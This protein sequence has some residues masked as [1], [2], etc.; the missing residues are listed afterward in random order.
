MSPWV[1]RHVLAHLPRRRSRSPHR[2]GQRFF[3]LHRGTAQGDPLSSLLFNALLQRV[4]AQLTPDWQRRHQTVQLGHTDASTLT[5]L[6]DYMLLAIQMQP[7]LN[8]C[9]PTS[10]VCSSA[11]ARVKTAFA[12]DK[13]LPKHVAET[14]PFFRC[15][16]G[17][18]LFCCRCTRKQKPRQAALPSVAILAQAISD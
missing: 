17:K 14:R 3:D 18:G 4:S 13:A 15:S 12:P 1:Q 7:N 11:K 8:Q 9:C 5:K 16:L 10:F 2:R 6:A